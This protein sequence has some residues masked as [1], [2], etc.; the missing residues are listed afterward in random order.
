MLRWVHIHIAHTTITVQRL[1]THNY[2]TVQRLYTHNYNTVQRLYTHNYSTVQRLYTHNYSTVQRL[3]THNYNTVE[4][5]YTHNYNTV[6]CCCFLLSS[7]VER[8]LPGSVCCLPVS[9]SCNMRRTV[10]SASGHY[11][12]ASLSTSC[13]ELTRCIWALLPC[14]SLYI[15]RWANKV[16]LGTSCGELASSLTPSLRLSHAN[17]VQSPCLHNNYKVWNLEQCV[18][19]IANAIWEHL[20]FLG[21][22]V[23]SYCKRSWEWGLS[24]VLN[25]FLIWQEPGYD[26]S[27]MITSAGLLFASFPEVQLVMHETE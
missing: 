10:K 7:F 22:L 25:F 24:V 26:A 16:R 2:S 1:Y 21:P 3:Y 8:W 11:C 6:S 14:L 12:L 20:R 19:E 15:M 18:L 9:C 17:I 23:A 27:S 5:L 4:R 13:G